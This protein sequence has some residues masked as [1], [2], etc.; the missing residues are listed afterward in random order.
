MQLEK[1]IRR[2]A[3]LV[4]ILASSAFAQSYPSK[5]VR[6]INP[7]PAGGP[8]DVV[9]RPLI[10]K[11][12]AELGQPFVMDYR[13]GAGTVI[14]SE[15]VAKA[16]A[17]GYTLLMTASQHAIN[18]SVYSKLPYDTAKDF[19][20]IAPIAQ[21]PLVLV[22]HP[23]V[24]AKDVRELITLAKARPGKL[25]F[26]SASSGSGFHMAGE[27]FKV[28]S[29][30]NIVHVPYKGGAPAATAVLAGEVE[31]L[32]SSPAT[33]L[34]NVKAGRLR[35]LAVTTPERSALMPELPTVVEAGVP[36][37][38]VDTWYGVFAPA[39]TPHE[40]VETLSRQIDRI[41]KTREMRDIFEKAGLEPAGGTPD[42]F[43]ARIAKD[44]AK[45]SKVAK[46]SGAKVD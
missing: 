44:M 45:W 16:A 7:F 25:N 19:A 11:L 30:V 18:P 9:G 4:G 5:P 37:F 22:V 31:M 10:E 20:P 28:L 42:Q 46:E 38:D 8:V 1:T 13:P 15:L 40:V 32:F 36:G 41:V 27:M 21:G 24:P 34:A 12:R 43:A 26:A 6:V 35:A 39:G 14:G 23:S 17:D 29:G 2:L 33:V 3:L